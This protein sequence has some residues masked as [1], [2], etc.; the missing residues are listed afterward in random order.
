MLIAPASAQL[1]IEIAGVGSSQIPVAIAAFADEDM[2]QQI[3]SIIK[4]DLNRSGYFKIIE[5][6]AVI[7]ETSPVN[8]DEWKKR[9]AEALVVGSVQRLADGRFDVRYKLLDT[10]KSA[11]YPAFCCGTPENTQNS[12]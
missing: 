3:T 4:D 9:G 12:T 7:T 10:M 1:R 6:G 2:P 8:F 5:A 11:P